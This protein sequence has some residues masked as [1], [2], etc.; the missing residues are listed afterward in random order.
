MG[1][2]W[3][4]FPLTLSALAGVFQRALTPFLAFSRCFTGF[5]AIWGH[6][7]SDFHVFEP[8]LRRFGAQLGVIGEKLGV[9]ALNLGQVAQFGPLGA[10][11]SPDFAGACPP[12]FVLGGGLGKVTR[13]PTRKFAG[14]GMKLGREGNSP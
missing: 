9:F 11:R 1:R 2:V 4:K 5:H 14:R 7:Y 8:F 3:A 12:E 6:F 10:L 13:P